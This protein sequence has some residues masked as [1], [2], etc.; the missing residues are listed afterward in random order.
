VFV[1]VILEWSGVLVSGVRL[2]RRDLES[3][4]RVKRWKMEEEDGH[5]QQQ[6][7]KTKCLGAE[8]NSTASL[9]PPILI[10]LL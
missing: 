9:Y 3:V 8:C 4:M 5:A 10:P 1:L 7:T 2:R 6:Q